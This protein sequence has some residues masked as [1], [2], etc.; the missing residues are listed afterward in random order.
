MVLRIL[1]LTQHRATPEQ[2]AAGVYD[3]PEKDRAELQ[4]LLTLT[5]E[6]FEAPDENGIR[7]SNVCKIL[8]KIDKLQE[9]IEKEKATHVLVGGIPIIVQR[10]KD[11]MEECSNVVML[12]SFSE[13]VSVD[14]PDGKKVSTFK[15]LFFY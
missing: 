1:N 15:H 11:I 6:D 12:E 13:R 14:G 4:N 8:D 5:K 7:H 3:L 9:I 2:V 10:L